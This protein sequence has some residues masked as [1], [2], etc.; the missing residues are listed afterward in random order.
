MKNTRQAAAKAGD[1]QYD[2]GEPCIHG[3]HSPRYTRTGACVECT[4]KRAKE[5]HQKIQ[6]MLES[7][8]K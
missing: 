5:Y 2:T 1:L 6:D 8:A 3:H 4:K 7:G